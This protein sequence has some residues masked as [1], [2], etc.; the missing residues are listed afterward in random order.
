[1]TAPPV[2][3]P[4]P[5]FRMLRFGHPFLFAGFP[6]LSL[7]SVNTD[8]VSASELVLPLLIA[9]LMVGALVV[10]LLA[11]TRDGQKAAL[12]ATLSAVM[13]WGFNYAHGGVALL[14]GRATVSKIYT[15][16]PWL[17]SLIAGGVLI[18]RTR[19]NLRST[20]ALLVRVSLAMTVIPLVAAAASTWSPSVARSSRSPTAVGAGATADALP[21][22]KPDI[23]FIILD[24]YA[25]ADVLAEIY[26]LHDPLP[27]DLRRLGFY[28]ADRGMANY[29]F[30]ALSVPSMLN[31]DYIQNL[32]ESGGDNARDKPALTRLCRQN[33]FI[34]TLKGYGYRFVAFASGV[35]FTSFKDADHYVDAGGALSEFQIAL[36]N[37]TPTYWPVTK[38]LR[39]VQEPYRAHRRRILEVFDALPALADDPAP[40]VVFAHLL[41]PHQPFVFGAR[42]EDVSPH[43]REYS[44]TNGSPEGFPCQQGQRNPHYVAAFRDQ[45]R[46]IGRRVAEVVTEILD[47][48]PHPPIIILVSDHGP[49]SAW[50]HT[51]LRERFAHLGAY[52]LPGGGADALYPS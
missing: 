25:R 26:G 49:D 37:R 18:A 38:L 28:V 40:T 17:L 4:R 45:T 5:V 14:L 33:A 42:G 41:A 2:S 44:L 9:W 35:H 22:G 7:Y 51:D 36:L 27:G 20:G 50:P 39:L 13:F 46:F 24:G 6:I 8:S 3:R 34:E 43:G 29:N 19:R 23:Y 12:I 32:L 21:Y 47:R 31:F 10:A 16:P 30:T 1:M 48:S 15:L 11:L 52:F